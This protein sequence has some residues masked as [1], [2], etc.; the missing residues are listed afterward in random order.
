M[1]VSS[2]RADELMRKSEW[3]QVS[4]ICCLLTEH[5]SVVP[6]P[7]LAHFR[8]PTQI[9]ALFH[10]KSP[11][12]FPSGGKERVHPSPSGYGRDLCPQWGEKEVLIL[13]VMG[14]LLGS[15]FAGC[16]GCRM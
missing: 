13:G 2:F 11:E 16:W 6:C 5:I 9:L 7:I 10:H 14:V 12:V 8:L 15:G 1:A 4:V 3:V